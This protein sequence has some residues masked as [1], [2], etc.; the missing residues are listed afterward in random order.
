MSGEAIITFPLFG[1]GFVLDPPRYFALFGVKIYF[2]GVIIALGFL[3]GLAY[4]HRRR[5]EFGLSGDNVLDIMICAVVGGIIGA[6]LYYIAFNPGEYFGPGKWGNILQIREGGL[7]IYGGIIAVSL[8]LVLYC[9]RKK[10]SLKKTLDVGV[11]ALLIGQCVGRWGNFFNREVFGYET[12]LPWRMG[13]T[14]TGAGMGGRDVTVFVHPAFLY[15]SLWNLIG[16][17]LLHIFS[18]RYRK[19]YDG[20]MFLLYLMWYGAGRF[21]IEGLRSDSLYIPG[22]GLRVSRLL[23]GLCVLAAGAV[24]L[25]FPQKIRGRAGAAAVGDGALMGQQNDEQE[26]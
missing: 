13:L 23:A 22:T 17:V 8:T 1:E 4:I 24:L 20:Q 16:F 18:K 7:A 10:L 11:L 2:Y 25:L 26:D 9:R 6:R 19:R 3:L 15:E 5:R 14:Y 21:L 12:T